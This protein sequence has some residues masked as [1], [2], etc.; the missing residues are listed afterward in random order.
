MIVRDIVRDIVRNVV[1]GVVR[2]PATF[3]PS[4]L[5][6]R[7]Y[8]DTTVTSSVWQATNGTTP[9]T[10]GTVLKRVDDLSGHGAHLVEAT[11]PPFLRASGALC[12]GAYTLTADFTTSLGSVCTIGLA[13]PGK[14][15]EILRNQTIGS[16]YTISVPFTALVVLD[17]DVTTAEFLNLRD[18]LT[19]KSGVAAS[20][21]YFGVQGIGQSLVLGT[22]TNTAGNAG[23]CVDKTN[24][25][26]R[27]YK[28]TVTGGNATYGPRPHMDAL[29]ANNNTPIDSTKVTGI[30]VLTEDENQVAGGKYGETPMTGFI[31]QY[32]KDDTYAAKYICD[33]HG[34]GGTQYRDTGGAGLEPVT[35][36]FNNGLVLQ[37]FGKKFAEAAGGT[38]RQLA[39]LCMHG[40]A[41]ASAGRGQANYSSDMQDWPTQYNLRRRD[42]VRTLRQLPIVYKQIS[43]MNPAGAF[44]VALGQRDAAVADSRLLLACPGYPEPH[45]DGTHLRSLS[46]RI[47]GERFG[48]VLRRVDKEGVTWRPL[49]IRSVSRVSTVVSVRFW[50][51]VGALVLDTTLVTAIANSGFEYSDDLGG[52]ATVSISSVALKV[53]TTDTIDVT[54][55][56]ITFGTNPLLSLAKTQASTSTTGPTAGARTNIRDSDTEVGMLTGTV[57]YNW[58]IHDQVAI[59]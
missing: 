30:E 41:D 50:V 46:E 22:N 3:D 58:A 25:D 6:A 37:E 54:L 5:G 26:P 10:T 24:H 49:M 39:F 18:W 32:L 7:G 15:A 34:R 33:V 21:L 20:A 31:A 2:A 45:S 36:H 28:F 8:Y 17:R 43:N 29:P 56:A 9:A 55:N 23:E 1:R 52:L 42:G 53:G 19:S 14:G 51:P 44:A 47:Q 16:T 13:I 27:A 38:Y 48:K 12:V 11:N 4:Q 59:P 40:E 57:L 35:P